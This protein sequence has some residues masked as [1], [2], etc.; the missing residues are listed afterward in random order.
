MCKCHRC[1]RLTSGI[2][3]SPPWF[4]ARGLSLNGEL[5]SLATKPQPPPSPP[6]ALG[7]WHTPLVWLLCRCR[8]LNL[9][10]HAYMASALLSHLP[11]SKRR[12]CF[13]ACSTFKLIG[14]FR[15]PPAGPGFLGFTLSTLQGLTQSAGL[16]P[17]S[18]I[19]SARARTPGSLASADRGECSETR[20]PQHL[21]TWPLQTS[22]FKAGLPGPGAPTPRVAWHLSQRA[23][24]K[25]VQEE[26][27]YRG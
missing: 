26:R 7:L 18:L 15:A 17:R 5:G 2:D 1:Q 9:G 8:G 27:G 13:R 23:V 25:L 4:A 3:C 16:T 14:S 22:E 6:P 19:C 24:S 21:F 20:F 11:S 12:C 10:P